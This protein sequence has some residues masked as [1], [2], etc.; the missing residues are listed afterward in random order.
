MNHQKLYI[1]KK[2][3][4]TLASSDDP[5]TAVCLG[6][7]FK[8]KYYLIKQKC[9]KILKLNTSCF[10][11][12]KKDESS[13]SPRAATSKSLLCIKLLGSQSWTN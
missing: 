8:K 1:Q 9:L 12:T 4:A 11:K 7:F 13:T 3:E 5:V 2:Y 6:I 10:E